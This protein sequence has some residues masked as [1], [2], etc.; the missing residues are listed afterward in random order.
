MSSRLLT[1]PMDVRRSKSHRTSHSAN[2]PATQSTET[3]SLHEKPLPAPPKTSTGVLRR[4][5]PRR[6]DS[7]ALPRVVEGLTRG[8]E[9]VRRHSLRAGVGLGLKSPSTPPPPPTTTTTTDSEITPRPRSTSTYKSRPTTFPTTSPRFSSQL[10]PHQ[11]PEKHG[12]EDVDPYGN[13][14]PE[15]C[16]AV[17]MT[18]TPVRV[19][20]VYIGCRG[21][22]S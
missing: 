6:Q 12:E 3:S 8:I 13:E 22:D 10:K 7:I 19:R 20:I 11:T 21:L 18:I 5:I 2:Y 14:E 16:I 9:K 4:L 15:L 17:E 1:S